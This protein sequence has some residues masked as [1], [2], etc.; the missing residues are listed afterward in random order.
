M[1]TIKYFALGD[2]KFT[3]FGN[4]KDTHNFKNYEEWVKYINNKGI[5]ETKN[6]H[7]ADLY[8]TQQF[9]I[10]SKKDLYLW[11]F[12][13]RNIPVLVWT[14]EPRYCNITISKFPKRF[15]KPEI[16]V[17]DVFTD[18]VFLNHYTWFGSCIVK[19]LNHIDLNHF[20]QREKMIC[21]L[22]TYRP[23]FEY[24]I[25]GENLDLSEY[26]Q[27]IA[28]EGYKRNI[29]DI[30]GRWWPNFIKTTMEDRMTN[31]WHKSKMGFL[32]KYKFN[33]CMENTKYGYYITEKIWDSI[34]A[35]CLPIYYGT[36]EI[37]EIFKEKSFV[38][39]SEFQ[40]IQNLLDYIENMS[41]EEYVQRL[42]S[43]IDTYNYA[44]EN[45][46]FKQEE[47]KAIDKAINKIH[48]ITGK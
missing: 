30:C 20:K 21:N 34:T 25:N 42:N 29:V 10:I 27:K 32:S 26:R 14:H 36:K 7:D 4:P 41:A 39:V 2:I 1:A 23:H 33:L 22:G 28:I 3:P 15:Y 5:V 24:Y 11:R 48:Q 9:P 31:D 45:I 43:C 38:D 17:M 16:N 13:H 18:D 47:F 37:Y 12:E 46:D 6:E 8:I 35:G 19:K 40:S 44:Y